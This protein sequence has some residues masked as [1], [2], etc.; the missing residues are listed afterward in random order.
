VWANGELD[1]S[2]QHDHKELLDRNNVPSTHTGPMAVGN[3]TVEDGVAIWEVV[4][5]AGGQALAKVLKKYTQQ[6]GWDWGGIVDKKSGHPFGDGERVSHMYFTY[7]DG[8]KLS[9]K[10]LGSGQAGRIDIFNHRVARVRWHPET[11]TRGLLLEGLQEWADDFGVKLAEY[12]GGSNMNDQLKNHSPMG[13]DLEIHNLGD[14]DWQPDKDR[15]RTPIGVFKCPDCGVLR[16]RWN[17]YLLHRKTHEPQGPT[18]ESE[19]GHFP[20]I[21]DG[22]YIE[23]RQE[24]G[25]HTGAKDPKDMFDQPVPFMYDIDEDKIH[26]G[27]PGERHSEIKIPMKYSPGGLVQGEYQPGG[28]VLINTV[29]SMPYSIRHLIGLWYYQHPEFEVTS[30]EVTKPDGKTHKVAGRDVGGYVATLAASDPAVH[31][32]WQALR[33][34]GGKVYVVGGAIRDALMHKTPKDIDLMVT[35]L[36]ADQ[37]HEVLSA[38]PGRMDITG[39]D[40][41]VF[42]YNFGENEVEV[43]MPRTEKSTGARRVD[44]DVQVDHNLPVETDLERRDFTANAIALDLDS[45]RLVDPFD[46]AGDIEKGIL[47]TVHPNSFIEDPTRIVRGLVAHARHGLN[48]DETTR[49]QMES[50]AHALRSEAPERIQAELDK[51]MKTDNP[52]KAIR[53]AQE[54]GVLRHFLP[55]VDRAFGFD[56]KNP[57]HQYDLGTHLLNVLEHTANQT[58]DPDVRMAALLHDIG[59]PDS[60]W[61]NPE[62]GQGHYYRN[63]ELGLG[64]DH[65]TVGAEMASKRLKALK[66]PNRRIERVHHLIANHMFPDFSS[67]RGARKFIQ[68]VGPEH[69]DD[70][71][72]LRAADRAGKGTDDYQ[73]MKTPVGQQKALVQEALERRAPTNT[74]DLAI[75]GNDLLG[76]GVQKGPLM[77][78]IL[79]QLTDLVVENPELNQRE[80]LLN[81]VRHELVSQ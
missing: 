39:K 57:H 72:V 8:V 45:G 36:P 18:V 35:G 6:A 20:E 67:D 27:A 40:F 11:K 70:L 47:K 37:V 58:Q 13:E 4:G 63:H 74:S 55:E 64:Q 26:V 16:H 54:T 49:A 33:K 66:Y 19:N 79:K 28:K 42:R 46:G 1:V 41:G 81:Y 7:Y 15:D 56:Q 31:N 65:E 75:N 25:I 21:N 50:H 12:P 30:V 10:P 53:L 48:P 29:T 5:N 52:A 17:E 76:I 44:F 77:G 69:A 68:R 23:M 60:Q 3:V 71:F 9:T 14:P 51:L 43:A 80:T 32:A 24:P 61:I 22:N 73:S 62:T 78:Q 34:A 2:G 38:L 59:K